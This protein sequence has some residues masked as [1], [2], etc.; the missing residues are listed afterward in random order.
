MSTAHQIYEIDAKIAELIENSIDP[1][2]GELVLDEDALSEL[3]MEKSE[4]IENLL[5]YYKECVSRMKA[6]KEEADTLNERAKAYKAKAERIEAAAAR[7]LNGE[8]FETPRVR[9]TFRKSTPLVVM[10]GF[11]E[12]AVKNKR[13]EFLRTKS[14]EV[15]KGAVKEA[16]KNDVELPFVYIDTKYNMSIE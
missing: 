14:P 1:E 7:L 2:T 15:E 4:K 13:M 12:W 3:E 9:V 11:I 10:D 5:L 8:K 6:I 16:L